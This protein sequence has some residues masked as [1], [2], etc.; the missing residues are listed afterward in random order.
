VKGK[1][2]RRGRYQ[3]QAIARNGAGKASGPVTVGFRIIG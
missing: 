1:P 3:L 2:L